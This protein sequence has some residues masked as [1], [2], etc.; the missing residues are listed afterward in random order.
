VEAAR[1]DFER[2]AE[3][4]PEWDVCELD[5]LRRGSA[6]LRAGTPPGLEARD[7]PSSV[8]PVL[9]LP[10]SMDELLAELSPKFRKNLRQAEAR[11]RREVA[12]FV[13]AKA[14]DVP[15]LLRAL[16]RLHVARWSLRYEPGMLRGEALQ[17]F[18]RDAAARMARSGT[19]R[20]NA[21][22]LGDAIL[23]V[24]HNLWH[25]RRLC[26]YLSGFDPGHARLSP[27]AVLLA[28]SIRAAIEE[29]AVE[30]DFLRHREQYKY[31]W[32]AR[33][34]VNRRLLVS[35]SAAYARDVA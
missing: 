21:I 22:R 1:A 14:E 5:E 7:A 19:L 23:A 33:D 17:E 31:Q 27:G 25:N 8:C 18:H 16:F 6:L 30:V 35:H 12:E 9:A 13:T 15:E 34:R 4:A 3:I 24:Q 32:G 26:Y 20:L 2:L 29:G 10:G 28:W 11:L